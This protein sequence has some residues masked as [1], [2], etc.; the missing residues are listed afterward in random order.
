VAHAEGKL[1]TRD[2]QVLQTLATNGQI[3]LTYANA[4]GSDD[5]QVA[6][7]ANPNGSINHIAGLS[8]PTGRVLG[9]M[10]HPERYLHRTQHPRWTRANLPET[11]DGLAIFQNV[12]HYFRSSALV[13]S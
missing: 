7:P 9:L 13:R 10:P 6:Y 2:P 5:A 8:D 1:V 11:G 12:V 3:A 4:P